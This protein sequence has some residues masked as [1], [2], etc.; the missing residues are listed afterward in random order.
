MRA[1]LIELT[2]DKP[3]AVAKR[4]MIEQALHDRLAV[5][6]GAVDRERMHVVVVGARDHAPLHVGDA[7][8]REQHDEV[9]LRAAAKCLDRRT[10]GVARGRHHDG[11]ALAA[12]GQHVVHQPPQELH[13]QILE[14]ERGAVKKLEH[15][16]AR[17]KLRERR[18]RR[19]A[20]RVVGFAHH[21]GEI[22]RRDRVTREPGDHVGG[23][24][25]VGLAGKPCDRVA[26]ELRPGLGNIKSA[27]AGEPRE[28]RLDKAE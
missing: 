15:E 8:V 20:E 10:A 23:D 3:H 24:F 13:R 17:P 19:M 25:R 1:K 16:C 28:R 7:S 27:V 22:G 4:V 26:I 12:L 2:P 5:V 14:G 18:H 6:E 11:R 9:D 21:A